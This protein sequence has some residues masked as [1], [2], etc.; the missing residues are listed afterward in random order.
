MHCIYVYCTIFHLFGW[1]VIFWLSMA[2]SLFSQ[3]DYSSIFTVWLLF[4][5]HTLTT[6]LFSHSDYCSIFTVWLRFY[7]HSLTTVLFSQSDYGS[8]FTVWLRFYFHILTTILFSQSD[9]GSIFTIHYIMQ[10]LSWW[11]SQ[12]WEMHVK[13][14]DCSKQNIQFSTWLYINS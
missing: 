12:R 11:L 5:F 7:F 4:Y 10:Y 13:H 3:S 9:Y 2:A 6:V 1:W 8:I 14:Q